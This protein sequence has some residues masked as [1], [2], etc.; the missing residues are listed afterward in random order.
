MTQFL[1]QCTSPALP[2]YPIGDPG[3]DIADRSQST[4]KRSQSTGL[5][6]DHHW[7]Q[8]FPL[9]VAATARGAIY[10]FAESILCRCGD[11]AGSRRHPLA[12]SSSE[13][14]AGLAM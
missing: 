9:C 2:L 10:A 6:S 13:S 1:L 8:Y 3:A 4:N 11:I 12:I 14:T 5:W 7:G